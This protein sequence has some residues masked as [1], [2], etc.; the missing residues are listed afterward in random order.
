M[1][2][3]ALT[4]TTA[5]E[6]MAERDDDL[7]EFIQKHKLQPAGRMEVTL[8]EPPKSQKSKKKKVSRGKR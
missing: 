7:V 6:L 4:G 2:G 5:F 8:P 3:V 1:R